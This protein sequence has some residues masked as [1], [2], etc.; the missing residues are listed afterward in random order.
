MDLQKIAKNVG[1]VA[2][3]I[4]PWVGIGTSLFGSIFGNKQSSANVDKQLA[5]Q[6]RENELN[7]KFNAEQALL[8]FQRNQSLINDYRRYSDPKNQMALLERAGLNP[9]LALGGLG[10]SNTPPISSSTASSNGGISPVGYSPIDLGSTAAL[11]ADARL[12]N[13]QADKL[14]SETITND[15]L[16]EGLVRL[17]SI[18]VDLQGSLKNLTDEQANETKQKIVESNQRVE[19]LKQDFKESMARVSK[20]KWD[21][22]NTQI[23]YYF[24]SRTFENNVAATNAELGYKVNKYQY[25]ND[26]KWFVHE[27][28][29]MDSSTSYNRAAAYNQTKQGNLA[30][31]ENRLMGKYMPGLYHLQGVRATFENGILGIEATRAL[32]MKSFNDTMAYIDRIVGSVSSTLD[33]LNPISNFKNAFKPAIKSFRSTSHSTSNSTNTNWNYT[34]KR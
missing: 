33:V 9:N 29:N 30:S 14:N 4:S 20:I 31:T 13:A 6:A 27:L 32:D 23:D 5:A 17:N 16:R 28:W 15:A 21:R 24:K 8:S 12:K 2:N 19:N 11:A 1:N 34:M 3:M 10:N 7:R 26:V 25:M 18:T 22:L